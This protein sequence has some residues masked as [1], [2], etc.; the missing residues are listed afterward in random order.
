L[1]GKVVIHAGPSE[2]R[3]LRQRRRWC[4]RSDT[5]KSAQS[6]VDRRGGPRRRRRLRRLGSLHRS[7]GLRRRRR[8]S[9]LH[10]FCWRRDRDRMRLPDMPAFRTT[11]LPPLRRK[12]RLGLVA[13]VASWTDNVCCHRKSQNGLLSWIC[14]GPHTLPKPID[15]GPG[16]QHKVPILR[17]LKRL[18]EHG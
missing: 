7:G 16:V 6:C 5:G 9:H 18:K 13:R 10:S 15:T 12:D 1:G 11:H 4:D 14:P 2:T 8:R 3:L 17:N